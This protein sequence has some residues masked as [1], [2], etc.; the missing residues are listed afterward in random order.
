M[1]FITFLHPSLQGD[2][3][4]QVNLNFDIDLHR[5]NIGTLTTYA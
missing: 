5:K 1:E 4:N 3:P 2:D